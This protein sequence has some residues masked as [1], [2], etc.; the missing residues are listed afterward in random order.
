MAQAPSPFNPLDKTNLG[1]SVAQALLAQ[2]KNPLPPAES[3][4]GAGVYLIYYTGKHPL[5]ASLTRRGRHGRDAQPIYAG[6]AIPPG[7][8]TGRLG[9]DLPAGN[10]L[11]SRLV[12]HGKSV[13]QAGLGPANFSCQY[14]VTE[15]IWIPLGEA[16]LIA[17]LQ[18]LWN[19]LIDG[20]GNHDPGG[21]RRG[22]QRS[23]WDTLH[24]GRSWA[25]LLQPN[26]A[27]AGEL[28]ALVRG[29]LAGEPVPGVI[30]PAEAA[31]EED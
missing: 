8:R 10:A 1:T 14:L 25:E 7:A 13:A 21:G 15:D 28:E 24:P 23:R 4:S 5:Y 22:Q 31:A 2:P 27:T 6:K 18:P 26:S 16:L 30:T 11:F 29:F 12:E 17:R 3:F 9:L 20:F 19:V